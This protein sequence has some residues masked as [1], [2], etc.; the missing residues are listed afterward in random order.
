MTAGYEGL[1]YTADAPGVAACLG[2]ST[3]AHLEAAAAG[4]RAALETIAAG[5]S[6]ADG[7]GVPALRVAFDGGGALFVDG[8]RGLPADAAPSIGRDPAAAE[9]FVVAFRAGAGDGAW[10]RFGVGT[11]RRVVALAAVVLG[12]GRGGTLDLEARTARGGYEAVAS[13]AVGAGWARADAITTTHAKAEQ[14]RVV[15]RGGG[16]A[17][18][19]VS[20]VEARVD[21]DSLTELHVRSNL[22]DALVALGRGARRDEIAAH[23]AAAAA[24]RARFNGAEV[25]R[26]S[27]ARADLASA[28]ARGV[29]EALAGATARDA[30]WRRALEAPGALE[31]CETALADG[32]APNLFASSAL[33]RGFEEPCADARGVARRVEAALREIA[34][35]RAAALAAVAELGA[36]APGS[37]AFAREVA[38]TGDCGGC[39]ADWGAAGPPCAN[40]GRIAAIDAC[41]DALKVERS[42]LIETNCPCSRV[43]VALAR[44]LPA[45]R[46]AAMP[47]LAALGAGANGESRLETA[48]DAGAKHE[49]LL[50]RRAANQ[51]TKV[52]LNENEALSAAR[53]VT[54]LSA[55]E[56]ATRLDDNERGARVYPGEIG[57]RALDAAVGVADARRDLDAARH[58]LAFL[59]SHAVAGDAPPEADAG[60]GEECRICLRALD[61]AGDDSDGDGPPRFDALVDVLPCGHAFH[62]A[63]LLRWAKR[64]CPSCRARYA[65]ADA[66]PC[67]RGRGGSAAAATSTRG[68]K[69]DAFL[70]DAAAAAARG[71]QSVV[72]SNFD[73]VLDVVAAALD[74]EGLTFARFG[75]TSKTTPGLA[76]FT[77]SGSSIAFL[78]A[79]VGRANNG[80]TLV[81]AVNV[82]VVEPTVAVAVDL[83]CVNRV[84]RVGQTRGTTVYRYVVADTIEAA[85]HGHH[86]ALRAARRASGTGDSDDDDAAAA[87]APPRASALVDAAAA[88]TLVGH[89][90]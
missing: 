83:Q 89:F 46:A 3:A 2:S 11:A 6:P 43:L 69:I 21:S 28:S 51:A 62:A 84:H 16:A 14:W 55:D 82:F 52:L 79:P 85:I 80:L 36:L 57:A 63:C 49:M 70:V 78:L 23:G 13:L 22:G 50:A 72:F 4:Y 68:T 45:Y 7:L 86:A 5:R 44:L 53:R 41:R 56:D 58:S 59:E 8:A 71:E 1:G 19:A 47:L 12:G 30:W 81:N 87:A 75:S 65:A 10:A 74:A 76:G 31:A 27:A 39:A 48:E 33:R 66:V 25:D 40:C 37:E 18:I 42:H 20:L 24:I 90:Y 32:A 77:A 26:L 17:R 34:A 15:F 35:T 67:V 60:P 88:A 73:A 29:A 38:A 9:A 54:V 64:E 61:D